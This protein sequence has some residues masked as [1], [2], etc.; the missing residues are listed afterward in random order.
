MTP[1]QKCRNIAEQ[2]AGYAVRRFK[3]GWRPS[4]IEP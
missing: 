2:F 3:D 4:S 1:F